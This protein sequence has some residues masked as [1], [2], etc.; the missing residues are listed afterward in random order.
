MKPF[1]AEAI[2]EHIGLVHQYIHRLYS[3]DRWSYSPDD[4]LQEGRL[5]LWN[6]LD[7][8]DTSKGVKFGTFAYWWI[9]RYLIAYIKDND[10][11]IRVPRGVERCFTR[12]PLLDTY[13][14]SGDDEC[15]KRDANDTEF[16]SHPAIRDDS[17]EIRESEEI[18]G[19]AIQS[20]PVAEQE[21]IRGLFFDN[22]KQVDIAQSLNISKRGM[23]RLVQKIIAKLR[24]WMDIHGFDIGDFLS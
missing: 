23:S 15:V 19:K 17:K 5:A 21:I 18:L 22:L 20:L 2:E 10:G 11:I 4:L 7:R 1:P 14:R 16:I 3:S 6:A 24:Q 9:R 8:Y 12:L 13:T